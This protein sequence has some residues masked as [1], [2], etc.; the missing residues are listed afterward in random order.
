MFLSLYTCN[1]TWRY[2]RRVLMK[3]TSGGRRNL[4][5]NWREIKHTHRRLLPRVRYCTP[6]ILF[7]P[8]ILVVGINKL[9]KNHTLL[10]RMQPEKGI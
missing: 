7:R 8:Q 9:W 6:T 3:R 2:S 10:A 1:T 5:V 4:A